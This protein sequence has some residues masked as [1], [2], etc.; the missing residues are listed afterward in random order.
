MSDASAFPAGRTDGLV[1][2]RGSAVTGGASGLVGQVGHRDRFVHEIRQVLVVDRSLYKL[3][4]SARN[5]ADALFTFVGYSPQTVRQHRLAGRCGLRRFSAW[6]LSTLPFANAALGLQI[7]K[8]VRSGHSIEDKNALAFRRAVRG[9]LKATYSVLA[10]P[11][12][13]AALPSN[14]DAAW[15]VTLSNSSF[16]P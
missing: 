13:A 15:I 2:G 4:H 11:A 9:Q 5:L 3:K 16:L 1:D 7:S 14:L 10:L 6:Q 8:T 12:E